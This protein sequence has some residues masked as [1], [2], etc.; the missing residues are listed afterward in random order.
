M[1]QDLE[2]LPFCVL[3]WPILWDLL[4]CSVLLPCGSLNPAFL[5]HANPKV[6][7]TS[8]K[9]DATFLAHLKQPATLPGQPDLPE[10]DVRIKKA[11]TFHPRAALTCLQHLHVR[12]M[13]ARLSPSER[14]NLLGSM[15]N[16]ACT[17]QL[18]ALG[19][20]LSILHHEGLLTGECSSNLIHVRFHGG[21]Q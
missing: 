6:I 1:L 12:G 9:A 4:N 16:M 2:G 3:C 14:L 11:T 19:A 13:P 5:Q 8:S 21:A 10:Y 17:Q 15:I 7:Y 20:L 18:S